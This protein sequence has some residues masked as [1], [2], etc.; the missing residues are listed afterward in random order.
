MGRGY[1]REQYLELAG[2]IRKAVPEVTLTTDILIGFP[3]ESEDDFRMT[4]ELLQAAQFDDAFTYRYNPRRGTP[5]F[6]FGD[7]VPDRLKQERLAEV[8]RVQRRI[9]QGRKQSRVGREQE[10]LVESISRKNPGELLARTE[11]DET[12]VFPGPP[13]SVGRFTRVRL[14]RLA[15]GTFR[16]EEVGGA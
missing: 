9:T 12:V 2:R 3:G 6:N 1:T 16:A 10:V 14:L 13:Q 4:L 15:G 11:G 8:I 5:A 7:D